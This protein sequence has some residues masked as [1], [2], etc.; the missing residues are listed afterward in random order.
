VDTEQRT[1]LKVGL[2]VLIGIVLLLLG[3]AWGKGWDFTGRDSIVQAVF[4][5]AGGLEVGDP[6]TING[7]KTGRVSAIQLRREDVVVS[8][9]F[10][11]Q[12]DIRRDAKASIMMLELMGGKK[13]ELLSGS[14]PDRLPASVP[15]QGSYEGDISTLVAMVASLSETLRSVTG[16]A[17][18]LFASLNTLFE[19]DRLQQ[20]IERT[21]G[22]AEAAMTSVD[23]AAGRAD[24]LLA[25]N[26]PGLRRTLS[27][28][29]EALHALN[30]MV[31]ENRPALRAF[32]DTSAYTMTSARATLLQADRLLKSLDSMLAPKPGGSLLNRLLNDPG[33]A[34]RFDSAL[35]SVTKLSE[36]IRLQGLDAN[37]R[38]FQSST[39]SK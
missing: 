25:E 7:V 31:R 18:T 26:A 29:E 2:T 24:R 5:T 38:F 11:K 34:Q 37:I 13:I 6:V 20:N 22:K 30:D 10:D 27:E 8:M 28:A 17:D 3:I 23:R 1:N 4:P 33:F 16:R 12:V 14:S 19:G 15:I 32:I 39:P 35:T 21:L 9:E 36:Q